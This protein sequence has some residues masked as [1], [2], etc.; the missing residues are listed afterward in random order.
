MIVIGW[1]IMKIWL[2]I[3]AM[4][5]RNFY[6]SV[7]VIKMS[8]V[9]K[10][11]QISTSELFVK[12]IYVATE[13]SAQVYFLRNLSSSSKCVIMDRKR[14]WLEGN[15]R[16][17][18]VFIFILILYSWLMDVSKDLFFYKRSLPFQ[19]CEWKGFWVE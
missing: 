19:L 1:K 5:C 9:T 11:V 17:S 18:Q 3:S 2:K 7:I 14:V 4:K 8:N 6:V 12:S 13:T 10:V 15:Q 16:N